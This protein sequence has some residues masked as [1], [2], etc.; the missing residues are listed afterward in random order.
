MSPE[1]QL[2]FF[3]KWQIERFRIVKIIPISGYLDG[4]LAARILFNIIA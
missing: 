2:Y 3:L 4:K 1:C